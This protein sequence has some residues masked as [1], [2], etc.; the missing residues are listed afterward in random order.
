M[1]KILF[2][3]YIKKS[4]GKIDGRKVFLLDNCPDYPKTIEDLKYIELFFF[5]LNTTSKI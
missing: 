4:N 5:L 2:Q 3:N 1:I